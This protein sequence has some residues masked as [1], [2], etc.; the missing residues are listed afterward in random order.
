MS[1]YYEYQDVKVAMYHKLK[2]MDGWKMYGYSPDH[3]DLMHDYYDPESWDGIAEKNGYILCVDV[4]SEA[5][6][7]E[8]REYDYE[9]FSYDTS[10]LEKIEK[11]KQMTVAR[12]ASEQEEQSAKNMIIRLQKKASENAE[13][14]NRYRVVGMVPGHMANPPRMNWHIE[15]D[16]VYVAKGNGILK[17]AKLHSYFVHLHYKKDMEEFR[18]MDR[19]KYREDLINSSIWRKNYSEERANAAADSHIKSMEEDLKLLEQFEAF[20]HKI[21]TTCGGMIGHGKPVSYEKK[22][23]KKY[24]VEKRIVETSEGSIQEGQCFVLKSNFSYGSYKGLVYRIHKTVYED[25]QVRYHAYKLNG[26][27]TKECTGR[28]SRNN[29]WYIGKE[30]DS[31]FMKW[32]NTGNIA[33]CNIQD[34]KVAHEVE[35]VVKKVG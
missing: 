19:N 9:G 29:F 35:K 33:W 4:S 23:V 7:L 11:L 31:S 10:V 14:A 13:N 15:K 32:I 28:A 1:T 6:P 34:V 5:K 25:G 20:I 2:S 27:L 21:D 22:M 24:K 30:E 26:K 8:I 16:G 17:F 3:S 12:G 18:T